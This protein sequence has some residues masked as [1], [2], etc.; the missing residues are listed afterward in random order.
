MR[1]R[2]ERSSQYDQ[3]IA[4]AS[5]LIAGTLRYDSAIST[6]AAVALAVQ[7]PVDHSLFIAIIIPGHDDP[8]MSLLVKRIENV[9]RTRD[10][11]PRAVSAPDRPILLLRRYR[12]RSGTVLCHGESPREFVSDRS[13]DANFT[14]R[15]SRR[16]TI[17][18]EGGKR[19]P[20][21]ISRCLV[22]RQTSNGDRA[23]VRMPRRFLI[24][25][26]E[27]YQIYNLRSTR[28][29]DRVI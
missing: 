3:R 1:E 6:I 7:R 25:R 23:V 20:A 17:P 29:T 28:V 13:R 19:R 27:A 5:D 2:K 18:L 8:S 10:D 4:F 26:K 11:S 22:K 24:K 12:Y 15:S 14:L 9:R 16:V 21:S